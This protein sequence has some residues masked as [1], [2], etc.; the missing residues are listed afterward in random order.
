MSAHKPPARSQGVWTTRIAGLLF[1]VISIAAFTTALPTGCSGWDPRN[2]FERNSPEVDEAIRLIESGQFQSA[3]E[4]LGRYLGTGVCADGGITLPDTVRDKYNGSFDMGL[5]I[6]HIAEKYGR[7]FGEEE[8]GQTAQESD[9]QAQKRSLEVDCA[10]IIVKAIASDPK[11][12]AE[13]RARARYLA[14]N[15][16]FLRKRYEEAVKEYDEALTLMPG[17]APDASGDGIGRDI[18]WNRAIALRRIADQKDAGNDSGDDADADA[19]D[20]DDADSDSPDSPDGDDGSDAAD[21]GDGDSGDD[22]G[23]DASDGDAGNKGD[24][25]DDGGPDSGDAAQPQNQP[26]GGDGGNE[27]PQSQPEPGDPE[28]AEAKKDPASPNQTQDDRILDRLEEAPS[29]QEEEAK[30]KA[31]GRRRTKMEDK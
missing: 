22:G 24:S 19:P 3:E 29:Y 30:K 21:S 1:A 9:P 14:G 11:I 8:E 7:P 20:S 27:D 5:V 17:I 31:A 25:G 6:F 26:D 23:N 15:L 28:P 12:P 16:E 10:L 13:L 2:P 4:I 18:A